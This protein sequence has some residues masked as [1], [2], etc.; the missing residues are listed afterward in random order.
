M[1]NLVH[2]TNNRRFA[3]EILK[4]LNE[5]VIALT[6]KA[7]AKL[8]VFLI[9]PCLIPSVQRFGNIGLKSKHDADRF[10][11]GHCQRFLQIRVLRHRGCEHHLFVGALDRHHSV[12]QQ[13]DF[14]NLGQSHRLFRVIGTQQYRNIE[15]L[16]QSL[17][18]IELRHEPELNEDLSDSL[19][20]FPLSQ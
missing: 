12:R 10:A 18:H 5:F 8:I 13:E 14:R 6:R 4:M 20:H 19:A 3:G 1:D 2:Q 16:G 9:A 11:Q 15:L 17:N 7:I